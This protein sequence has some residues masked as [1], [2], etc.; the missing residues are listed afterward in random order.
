MNEDRIVHRNKSKS[1]SLKISIR[2]IDVFQYL[3]RKK[4]SQII[5]TGM[6]EGISQWKLDALKREYRNIM[7][8]PH[9]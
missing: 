9:I 6:K 2:L 7:K 4:T 5:N 8:I 1:D 3:H